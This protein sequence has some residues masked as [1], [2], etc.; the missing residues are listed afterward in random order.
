MKIKHFSTIIRFEKI[1]LLHQVVCYKCCNIHVIFPLKI[2]L[3]V[4][5]RTNAS[6]MDI[7]LLLAQL[8][9]V[10]HLSHGELVCTEIFDALETASA[11]ARRTIIKSLEDIVD[12]TRHND[13]IEKLMQLLPN[14]ADLL[15]EETI[16]TFG[17]MCLSPS[18][19][20]QICQKII[21]YIKNNA[22][23]DVSSFH[24][25]SLTFSKKKMIFFKIPPVAAVFHKIHFEI[26]YGRCRS[27]A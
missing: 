17:N 2:N 19:H 8:K 16:D 24:E 13:V 3:L 5:F 9:F 12:L 15:T 26:Q 23:N 6:N 11:D 22:P 25:I 14:D 7:E 18:T 4:N 1:L 20:S 10:D 21:R 27:I